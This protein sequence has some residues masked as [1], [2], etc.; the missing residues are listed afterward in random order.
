MATARWETLFQLPQMQTAQPAVPS[1]S[2]SFRPVSSQPCYVSTVSFQKL[3]LNCCQKE[4]EKDKVNDDVLEK[5]RHQLEAAT[6]ASERERL[7]EDLEEAKDKAHRRSIGN[8]KFIG[9]LFKLHMLSE[10]IMHD[11]VV[12][13]FMNHSEESLERLCHLLTAIGKDLDLEKARPKMDHYFKYMEKTVKER[14]G[15]SRIRFLLQ[16]VIDLRLHNWV[17]QRADHGP[18]TIE[19]IHQ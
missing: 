17:S 15:S 19:Q 10:A 3:L 11:C 2:A 13:L 12:K 5:L 6:S 14:R 18:K 16:D 4:F 9:E 1:N 7:E 8:I